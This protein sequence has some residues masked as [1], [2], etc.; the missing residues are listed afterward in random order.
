V[1]LSEAPVIYSDLD[2]SFAAGIALR[3]KSDWAYNVRVAGYS[4]TANNTNPTDAQLGN[5][6]NWTQ[7][8]SDIKLT[9][10]VRIETA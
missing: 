6:G 9:A 8:F 4:M 10:G 2:P 7:A 1:R 3:Y 5:G